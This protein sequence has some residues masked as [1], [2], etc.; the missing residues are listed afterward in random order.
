MLVLV[1]AFIVPVI[2]QNV[3]TA[4][5]IRPREEERSRSSNVFLLINELGHRV[6]NYEIKKVISGS[7]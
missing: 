1:F 2:L 6:I 4:V 3:R 5:K 7:Y